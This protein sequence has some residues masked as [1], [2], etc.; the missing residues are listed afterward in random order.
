MENSPRTCVEPVIN[1]G[2]RGGMKTYPY[3][4]NPLNHLIRLDSRGNCARETVT[5]GDSRGLA[6]DSKIRTT[7]AGRGKED[8]LSFAPAALIIL[9]TEQE[10]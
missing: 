10:A 2:V 8:R 6:R 1:R 7:A 4:A 5:S 3:G 9:A